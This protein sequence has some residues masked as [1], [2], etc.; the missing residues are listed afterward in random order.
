MRIIKEEIQKNLD[1]S[2]ALMILDDRMLERII[3]DPAQPL[4]DENL[5]GYSREKFSMYDTHTSL[6]DLLKAGQARGAK[7]ID[8]S[9][10]FFFGGDTRKNFPDSELTV[11]AYKVIHDVAKEYGLGFSASIVSPL[12]T[13]GGYVKTHENAGFT[14]QYKE[15]LIREDGS[16]EVD[17]DL[18]TQWTNNKGPMRLTLHE[19]KAYAFNEE[20]IADTPYFYVNPDEIIDI[21]STVS[22]EKDEKNGN[23]SRDA[24]GHSDIHIHGRAENIQKNRCLIVLIYKTVEMD[25]FAEDALSYMKSIID[26]HHKN[27]I[28]YEGFYADEMHI[29]FDWDMTE[30]FAETEVNTRYMTRAMAKAYAQMYGAEFEDFPKYLIYFAYKHHTFLPGDAGQ[31]LSQHVLGKTEDDIIRTWQFRRDYYELLHRQVVNLCLRTK[32]YAE[33]LYGNTIMTTGHSTWQ[34]CP[35]TDRFYDGQNLSLPVEEEH[36]LYDYTPQFVWSASIRENMSACHDHFKWSDYLCCIGTDIPECGFLDRNYYGAAFTS[37]LAVLNRFPMAYYCIWGSPD[38][39]KERIGEVGVTYGH[40]ANYF[41]SYEF[42]HNLLQGYTSRISEI[43]TVCPM[44]LNSVEERFGSWMVQYGYTDYI[45]EEKLLEFV[46]KPCG[47]RLMVKDRAYNALVITYSPLVSKEMLLLIRDY[48]NAGGT[49]IWCASPA[50]N[51]ADQSHALF[52]EIFG[53]EDVCRLGEKAKG[54]FVRFPG[55]DGVR[56]MEILTDFRPDFVY[57]I[58]VRDAKEIAY[59]QNVCLGAIREGENGGKAVYLGFRP[60]DDQSASTGKDVDTLFRILLSLGCYDEKGPEASSRPEGSP[61][62]FN[63]FPNGTISLANH[64]RLMRERGWERGFYRD[65][66]AD[67]EY[68]KNVSLPSRELNLKG[69]EIL[70]LKVAYSGEGALSFRYTKEEG[71][72]GL[73][74]LNTTGIAVDGT[75]Y[76]F[77]K[78][79]CGIAWFKADR[80]NL[81]PNIREA[82]AFK[83]DRAATITLPFDSN[84]MKCERASGYQ[85]NTVSPYPFVSDG[86]K[87]VVE[88]TDDAVQTWLVFYCQDH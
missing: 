13:G 4:I 88:V 16:Y 21:S 52:K 8:V 72:T 46:K 67:N 36:S 43:L 14:M 59:I 39:V 5:S 57:P 42:G 68:M 11:K 26:L 30:H 85:L 19:V 7:R 61:Y 55:L 87:T 86:N 18:Q 20:R 33:K 17:M 82:Y 24:F 15:G 41:K 12:D 75:N 49:V 40:Y 71:L 51:A 79:K 37:G 73:I 76:E 83:C 48:V 9:Y 34:E 56:D 53:L 10:D 81:D 58:K 25:Y 47:K 50:V 66:E 2:V 65:E 29:Q 28:A 31:V 23:V 54:A 74:G 60:R 84:G 27:G 69:D 80:N 77:S 44:D 6:I 32:E 22:Y 63:R 78:E 3:E 64:S 1:V 35:T 45:T 62:I 70:G 38:A